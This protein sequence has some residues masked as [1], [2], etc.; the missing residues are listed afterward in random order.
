MISGYLCLGG[1]QEEL[2]AAYTQYNGE[3]VGPHRGRWAMNTD[4]ASTIL[5]IPARDKQ[6]QLLYRNSIEKFSAGVAC[7]D[8]EDSD[9]PYRKKLQRLLIT[10]DSNFLGVVNNKTLSS[11][12]SLALLTNSSPLTVVGLHD[13][14]LR[15]AYVFW[16]SDPQDVQNILNEY[17]MRFLI[18]RFPS[19]VFDVLFFPVESICSRWYRWSNKH[20]VLH[21][22]NAL[23]RRLFGNRVET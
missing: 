7:I 20:D 4:L 1:G 23:E 14:Q 18:Y 5:S 17:P 10:L 16:S 22:F 3:P 6:V 12:R 9:L 11:H 15:S 19:L 8:N 13:T 21:A 2:F